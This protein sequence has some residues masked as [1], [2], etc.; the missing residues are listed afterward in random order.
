MDVCTIIAKNYV[1]HARVLA[2]SLAEHNPGSRL[3]TLIID[4]FD[5]YIDPAEEPFE[6]LAPT[7]IG[8]DP[9][10]EMALTYTVLELSTAVKPW[11]LR[12]LMGQTGGPVT[13]L[14]PDIKIYGS[15]RPLDELARRHGVVL[16]PHN[17]EP[18]PT[19]GRKP[20]QIDIMLSGVY[21]LGY[22]SLAPRADVD[23][24]MDWWAERLRYDCRVDHEL[25]FFVDQRWFDLVPG[26]LSDFAVVR[27]PEYN[28]AYWNLHSRRL[29]RTGDRYT[30]DGRELAFF[31]FSGFDPARPLELSHHQDRI[32]VTRDAVLERLL[33]EY[34]AE[35]EAQGHS[36][37]RKWPYSYRAL[38]DGTRIDATVRALYAEFA[39][40]RNQ[41][42]AQPI[43]PFTL[44]GTTAFKEWLGEQAPGASTSVTR[45]LDIVDGERADLGLGYSGNGDSDRLSHSADEHDL[46][47]IPVLARAMGASASGIEDG[48]ER[49]VGTLRSPGVGP[50][51]ALRG[52]PWGVNVI[53][54]PNCA[55]EADQAVQMIVRS[56]DLER[57]PALP[58]GAHPSEMDRAPQ[59]R[60]DPNDPPFPVNVFTM[61]AE[62]MFELGAQTA[63]EVFA[64]RYSIGVW[65]WA[66]DRLPAILPR[67]SLPVEELWAPSAYVEQALRSLTSIP[68]ITI[69]LPAA[70]SAA[71][72]RS[73]SEL[74]LET[75]RFTF[76]SSIDYSSGFER[77]NPLAVIEAFRL[78]FP[79]DEDVGLVLACVNSDRNSRRHAELVAA[80]AD[81]PAIEIRECD[82]EGSAVEELTAACDV[83]ASLHRAEAFGRDLATAMWL[84]KTV[85]ATGYSGNLDF[86]TGDNSMLV[87]HQLVPIGPSAPPYPADACWADPSAE[88][89]AALMR[90]AFEH[91]AEV[92]RL[93]ARAADDIRRS[94]STIVAAQM[95]SRRLDS[96]S[97]TGRPR[98]SRN[99]ALDRPEGL[100]HLVRRLRRG[101]GPGNAPRGARRLA[102]NMVL[103]VMRPF[104]AY[105]QAVNVDVATALD[106]V[107]ENV[108]RL[109]REVLGEQAQLLAE[110]RRHED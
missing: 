41:N 44:E 75:G 7:E 37:S 110:L 101:I 14:D 86:M 103:R 96:I 15:L 72:R 3:W 32:D 33:A 60:V 49:A 54:C 71:Q 48:A 97:A 83:Y 58:I 28:L 106:D 85:I 52:A 26:F 81:E 47:E 65:F 99:P 35:T 98:H 84:R 6:V 42:G 79:S 94:H 27:E 59:L 11:L 78:A 95:M 22:V 13:Y 24:L 30:V 104:T 4:D 67:A 17:S 45:V 5:R 73:R 55:L 108:V 93:G 74:G 68:V 82:A 53:G 36:K 12:H 50:P 29:E 91:P 8:C 9:F 62:T 61:N 46:H 63:G 102:R 64:G 19:D 87:D 40:Q 105:Q 20:S 70:P 90:H 16:I 34:A 43:S 39:D 88:H 10:I 56:L 80:V 1:A 100:A 69:P 76:C 66:A 77:K 109:R 25:G 51:F 57:I 89:A 23:R 92:Q 31:H 107:N 18:I 21:N 2:Q 38:G